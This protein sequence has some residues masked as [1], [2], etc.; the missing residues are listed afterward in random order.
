MDDVA[1]AG[2]LGALVERLHREETAV[3]TAVALRLLRDLEAAEEVVQEAWVAALASWRAG[4]VPERPGAWL[5]VTVRRRALDR[6]RA[7]RRAPLDLESVPID[8]VP[9]HEPHDARDNEIADD[10]LRLVF[11][12]CHPALAPEAQTALT[13]RLVVGLTLGEIARAYLVPEA[14]I[15]QRLVRAKRRLRELGAFEEPSGR[16]EVLAR[17]PPV[18]E[19]VYLLFNEGY[20]ASNGPDL[21]RHDLLDGAL[22]LGTMLARLLP[23]EPEVLGLLAL[24]ELQAS[25]GPARTDARGALVLLED[26]DRSRWDRD[27]IDRG[28]GHLARALALRRPGAYQVQ[29]AIAACHAE[30]ASWATTDWTQILALYGRLRRLTDSP[31]VALNEI[32]ALSFVDGAGAALPRL[33]ALATDPRLSGHHRVEVVRADLLRRL[34]RHA[35]ASAAYARAAAGAPARERE[36]LEARGAAARRAAEGQAP[37]PGDSP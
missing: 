37:S 29:A 9:S 31:V 16:A 27:L 7:R 14:T 19:V 11:T 22:R 12:C 5:L 8:A 28:L 17:L 33:E 35:E 13:L 20:A 10:Q 36:L 25:R 30:A 3:L 1:A 6:L 34:G 2:A 21:L 15:A 4:A 18:L 26:Q 24:L 32:V 23:E